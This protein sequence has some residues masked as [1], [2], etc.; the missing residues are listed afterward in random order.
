MEKN[1][2]ISSY[3]PLH[4]CAITFTSRTDWTLRAGKHFVLY[5]SWGFIKGF[6]G[7]LY[8]C[9]DIF[10]NRNVLYMSSTRVLDH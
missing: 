7:P 3:D 6:V 8:T 10:E 2:I 5:W 9:T 4:V 1:V